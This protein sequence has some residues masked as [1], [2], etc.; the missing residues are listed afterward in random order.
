ML[1]CLL[2]EIT[3]CS[4]PPEAATPVKLP[5]LTFKRDWVREPERGW[6]DAAQLYGG[7]KASQLAVPTEGANAFLEVGGKA[8]HQIALS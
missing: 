3:A 7:P 5:K 4:S 1:F 8:R 2:R 6:S